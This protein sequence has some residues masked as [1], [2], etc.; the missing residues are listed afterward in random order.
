MFDGA[1]GFLIPFASAFL[2]G[3]R[4]TPQPETV[5]TLA[6]P[7]CQQRV[8]GLIAVAQRK[9]RL[10]HPGA[11]CT[12]SYPTEQARDDALKAMLPANAKADPGWVNKHDHM[13]YII[14]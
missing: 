3:P 1:L 12:L 8:V 13:G 7:T 14:P 10:H 4:H 2:F 11:F 6:C 5:T 9:I